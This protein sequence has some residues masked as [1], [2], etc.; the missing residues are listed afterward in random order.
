M[1]QC[2]WCN[3]PLP[4]G[5]RKYCSD[6]C[7]YL[8]WREYIAILWWPNAKA[9]ALERAGNQCAICGRQGD[10]EVHHIIKL[11]SGESYHN[12]P[13]NTQDNLQ[14]LC[15]PCHE[16]AHHPFA[17]IPPKNQIPKEQLAMMLL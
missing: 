8:Y 9:V 16:K 17:G 11:D 10:L 6:H 1:K 15:R 12:S 13:K 5:R 2:L 3:K 7:G 4:K 14:V